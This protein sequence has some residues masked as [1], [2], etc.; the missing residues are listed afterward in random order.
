MIIFVDTVSALSIAVTKTMDSHDEVTN[1]HRISLLNALRGVFFY[2]DIYL[3]SEDISR[4]QTLFYERI[5]AHRRS[6]PRTT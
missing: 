4:A 3:Y 1:K 5:R 2:L 6:P